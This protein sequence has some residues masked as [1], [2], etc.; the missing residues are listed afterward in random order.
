MK[1]NIMRSVMAGLIA[2][3]FIAVGTNAFAGKGMGRQ[4]NDRGYGSDCRSNCK[5]GCGYG[6]MKADLTPEQQEQMESERKAF[7]DATQKERQD[8]YAKQLELRA[9]MAKSEPDIQK[10]SALQKEVTELGGNL[11]QK[12]LNHIMAMRKINPNAGRG[13]MMEGR[14]MGHHRMGKGMG[15]GPGNCR[16]Q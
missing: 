12:H 14:G 7:F 11:D 2:V 4:D 1:T 10:A 13:F 6:Q 15:Y 8:L 3:A 16:N 5:G 9:E